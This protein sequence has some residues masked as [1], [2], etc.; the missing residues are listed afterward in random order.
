[1]KCDEPLFG[2]RYYDCCFPFDEQNRKTV[3][4]Y[5]DA[6]Q[7]LDEYLAILKTKM[8]EGTLPSF[9]EEKEKIKQQYGQTVFVVGEKQ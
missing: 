3:S 1:L 6:D 5:A 8:L 2:L 4:F 7:Y 9:L